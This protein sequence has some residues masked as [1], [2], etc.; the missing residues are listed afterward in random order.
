M[1]QFGRH[2]IGQMCSTHD[3]NHA[4]TYDVSLG[5][6]KDSY[7]RCIPATFPTIVSP[8]PSH[9]ASRARKR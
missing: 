5:N 9:I 7:H 8:N 2:I 1:D 4:N 6:S 3:A